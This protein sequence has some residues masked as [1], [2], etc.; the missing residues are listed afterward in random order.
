MNSHEFTGSAMPP[1]LQQLGIDKLS[2]EDRLELANALWDHVQGEMDAD[3]E[4][5]PELKAELD[6]RL[7]LADA[8]PN[9]GIPWEVVLEEAKARWSS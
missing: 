2:F 4:I 8:D 6:R 1:T 3:T 9:R 7:A 5:S